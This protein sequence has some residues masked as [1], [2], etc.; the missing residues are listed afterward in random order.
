M[1]V[2]PPA[3]N[4]ASTLRES[5][6]LSTALPTPADATDV[7]RDLASSGEVPPR[8]R[9]LGSTAKRVACGETY[10]AAGREVCVFDRPKQWHCQVPGATSEGG[11][12]ACDDATDCRKPQLC[13]RSFSSSEEAYQCSE[14]H[15]NCAAVVCA[16]PDGL[17]CP[18]GQTCTD[19]YCTPRTSATCGQPMRCQG[20]TPFCAWS[21]APECVDEERAEVL[22]AGLGEGG[23][24]KGVYGCTV[25]SDCGSFQ[26]CTDMMR[27]PS[28][29]RCSQRCDSLNGQLVCRTDRDCRERAQAYCGEDLQCRHKVRCVRAELTGVEGASKDEV[30]APPWMKVCRLAE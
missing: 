8:D 11:S 25:P 15:G 12:Y 28:I 2:G 10:C 26:C 16:A 21:A 19:G 1:T 7:D 18:A 30:G 6:A 3:S 23:S 27:G 5:V 29:T 20:K 24:V 9:G 14:P 4:S 22:A 13:C 17:S